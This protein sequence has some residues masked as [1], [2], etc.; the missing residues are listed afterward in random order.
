MP[1]VA[2]EMAGIIHQELCL[3]GVLEC[4]I[5]LDNNFTLTSIRDTLRKRWDR[6]ATTQLSAPQRLQFVSDAWRW[7]GIKVKPI[8]CPCPVL[9]HQPRWCRRWKHSARRRSLWPIA[10]A[11]TNLLMREYYLIRD[12]NPGMTTVE[13]LG[14]AQ[15]EAEPDFTTGA[16]A[17]GSHKAASS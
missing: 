1:P 11:S 5:L 9:A 3:G 10:D 14:Q 13:A 2:A 12:A 17:G 4:E 15:M 8:C 16:I 6:I 7:A